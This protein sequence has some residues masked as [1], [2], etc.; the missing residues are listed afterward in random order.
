MRSRAV[1]SSVTVT[2]AKHH[3]ALSFTPHRQRSSAGYNSFTD[4]TADEGAAA[5]ARGSSEW[6]CRGAKARARQGRQG[7]HQEECRG[8]SW[9]HERV[10]DAEEVEGARGA[11]PVGGAEE[12]R[13]GWRRNEWTDE[14]EKVLEEL[15]GS[16]ISQNKMMEAVNMTDS[17]SPVAVEKVSQ[18]E[19]MDAGR[20]MQ[21]TFR[22]EAQHDWISRWGLCRHGGRH[23]GREARAQTKRSVGASVGSRGR[24]GQTAGECG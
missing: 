2:C 22:R 16:A 19:Q 4:G 21:R 15:T 11:W 8:Q 5:A 20:R 14:V 9:R 13:D 10:E 3:L 18:N 6:K 12:E 1:T 23:R 17:M 7:R 24:V